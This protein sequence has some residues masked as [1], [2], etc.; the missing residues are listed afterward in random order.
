MLQQLPAKL[1]AEIA[2]H[3]H[4]DTLR[5]VRIFQDCEEGLLGELVLKLKL[6]VGVN[7]KVAYT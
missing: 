1:Q 2:M 7:V 6:Q 4:F 5:K 3:V